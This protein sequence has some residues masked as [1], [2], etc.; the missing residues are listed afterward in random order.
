MQAGARRPD[1]PGGTRPRRPDD[2]ARIGGGVR[3]APGIENQWAARRKG[4]SRLRPPPSGNWPKA[5]NVIDQE[6]RD[7]EAACRG[8]EDR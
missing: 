2:L 4:Q 1:L 7:E 8:D 6:D 3:L 5:S